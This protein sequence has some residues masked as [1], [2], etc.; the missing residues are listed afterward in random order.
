MISDTDLTIVLNLYECPFYST[1]NLPKIQF[2]KVPECKNC[3]DYCSK[4]E[5]IK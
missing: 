5:K 1:C 2:C 4:W 3:P